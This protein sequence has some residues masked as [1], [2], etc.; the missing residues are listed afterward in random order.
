M[1]ATC[2]NCV[3][4]LPN[5]NVYLSSSCASFGGR[6]V[7]NTH[8]HTNYRTSLIYYLARRTSGKE[9]KNQNTPTEIHW[10]KSLRAYAHT[11]TH[12]S[13]RHKGDFSLILCC[14]NFTS[15]MQVKSAYNRPFCRSS[16]APHKKCNFITKT[17][18]VTCAKRLK[19][20]RLR[21]AARQQ[22]TI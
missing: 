5:E 17:I 8:T 15:K 7:A 18:N 4:N 10:S 3:R 2:W 14:A 6:Y 11:H 12:Q 22:L 19:C 21:L 16:F 13:N 9:K 1:I 20:G